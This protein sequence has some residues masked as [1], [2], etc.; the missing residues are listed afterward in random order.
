MRGYK[1][2]KIM[3]KIKTKTLSLKKK[4]KIKLKIYLHFFLL[5]FFLKYILPLIICPGYLVNLQLYAAD[6]I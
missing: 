1:F 4:K 3:F 2:Y 6:Q 5:F